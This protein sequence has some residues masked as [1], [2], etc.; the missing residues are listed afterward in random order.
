MAGQTQLTVLG[1]AFTQKSIDDLN[2]NASDAV[3]KSATALQ[4]IASALTVVGALIGA[5]LAAATLVLT[6]IMKASGVTLI[7]VAITAS[8]AI[9]PHTAACYVIT[10]SSAAAA[11]TL[12]APTATTDDGIIIEITADGSTA[13]AHTVTATG[14]FLSGAAA[15]DVATFPAAN[16]ASIRLMAYQAKWILLSNNLVV[17][18]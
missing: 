9:D 17:M 5:S 4:T 16:G 13:R 18:S 8:G 15:V 10:K 14:L 6:G 2:A 3:S 11:M 1:G 12:A 7:P